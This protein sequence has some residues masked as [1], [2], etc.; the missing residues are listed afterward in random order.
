MTSFSTIDHD[1]ARRL[2]A[3]GEVTVIDVR[4]PGEYAQLGHI[5]NAWLMPV[6]L[7]RRRRRCCRRTI[8]RYWCIAS[9]ACEAL[10]HRGCWRR[11]GS[12]G[13][14]PGRRPRRVDGP[15]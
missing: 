3:S 2:L 10:P 7:M 8:A 15:A 6:D 1:E 13:P 12:T 5:P 4:T 11:P 9:T 14:E